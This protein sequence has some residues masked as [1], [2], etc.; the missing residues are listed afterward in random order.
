MAG[1]VC[2][3]S[4]TTRAALRDLAGPPG[5]TP[6]PTGPAAVC[7]ECR[8]RFAPRGLPPRDGEARRAARGLCRGCYSG[9]H[10]AGTL[11]PASRRPT[12]CA[13]PCGR[14]LTTKA[15]R[16]PGYVV[17]EGGGWCRACARARSRTAA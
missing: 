8:R 14:P 16:L 10:R 1:I 2:T 7:G 6:A 12:H 5:P 17:H 3:G 9:A 13:G 4:F 15:R 11:T